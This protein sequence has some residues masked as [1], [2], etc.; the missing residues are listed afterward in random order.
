MNTGLNKS[1]KQ[2]KLLQWRDLFDKTLYLHDWLMH[3]EYIIIDVEEEA[4]KIKDYLK[5]R[6]SIVNR[7]ERNGLKIPI[8]HELL[9]VCQ[10]IFCHG[11]PMNYDTCQAESNH[12]PMNV[13]S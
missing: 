4:I 3:K 9:H 2:N 12:H 11:P 13:L 8:M 10:D 7:Q 1:V 5:L 6:K